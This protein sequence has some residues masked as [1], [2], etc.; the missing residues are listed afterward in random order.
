MAPRRPEL[1][2]TKATNWCRNA[3]DHFV[4]A[5]LE[6]DGLEP[7]DEADLAALIR[8][9]TFDITGLPPTLPDVEA[10]ERAAG[11]DRDSAYQR[12]VDRLLA[13]PQYGVRWGQCFMN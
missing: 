13:S 11:H 8:R 5:R 2:A 7:A 6:R 1:P 4:L 3:I 9:A 10:F 12:L